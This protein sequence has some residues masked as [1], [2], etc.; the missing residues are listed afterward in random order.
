MKS[1]HNPRPDS[2]AGSALKPN[3]APQPTGVIHPQLENY[4]LIFDNIYNGVMVTDAE[5]Y[6]THFN[7]PYGQFLGLDPE[8][9]IGKHCTEVSD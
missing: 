5:G 8:A 1:D 4:E 9:Q 7:R 6:V 2:N 3:K